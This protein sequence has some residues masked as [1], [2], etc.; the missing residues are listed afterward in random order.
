MVMAVVI[1]AIMSIMMGAAVQAVSFQMQRERE[2]ELIFRGG[3]FIEAVRLYKKLFGRH[4]MTL[5]EI[6]E[7]KPKVVRRKW[8]DPMTDSE[9]WGLVFVGQEGRQIGQRDVGLDDDSR[10][11]SPTP[12]PTPGRTPRFGEKE[13]PEEMGPIVGVY[14]TSCEASVKI[15]EGR[16]KYCDWKFVYRETPAARGGKRPGR[17]ARGGVHAPSRGDEAGGGKEN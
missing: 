13:P 12:T 7:S 14:S 1:L 8:K 11:P 6:W 10:K 16:T 2:A 15:Y 3:Q 17:R 4:P 9:R 5:K